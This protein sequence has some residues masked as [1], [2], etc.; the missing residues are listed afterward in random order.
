M[1]DAEEIKEHPWFAGMD[2]HGLAEKRA[3]APYVPQLEYLCDT[4]H[5]D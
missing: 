3:V 2:W 4:R 5:F 1:R